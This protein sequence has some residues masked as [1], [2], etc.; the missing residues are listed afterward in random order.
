MIKIINI[1]NPIND[2]LIQLKLIDK[3]KLQII[4]NSTR[5]EKIR[6]IKDPSTNLIFLEKFK[7]NEEYYKFNLINI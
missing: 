1:T 2:E 4:H 7:T 6:V 5:D 3:K